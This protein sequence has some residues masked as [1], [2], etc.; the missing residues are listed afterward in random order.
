VDEIVDLI[1]KMDFNHSRRRR[2]CAGRC[3]FSRGRANQ[4]WRPSA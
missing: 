2:S 3:P 1:R 4:G